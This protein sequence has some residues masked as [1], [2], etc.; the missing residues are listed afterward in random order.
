MN[1]KAKYHNVQEQSNYIPTI[2][3][4]TCNGFATRSELGSKT[5]VTLS[6]HGVLVTY[7]Q[8]SLTTISFKNSS[9]LTYYKI[10]TKMQQ[11]DELFLLKESNT[12]F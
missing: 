4:L 12:F 11:F 10:K 1:A 6:P 9:K 8:K 2:K 3:G 5:N 7:N